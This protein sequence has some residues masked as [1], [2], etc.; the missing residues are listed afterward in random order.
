MLAKHLLYRKYFFDHNNS[1]GGTEIILDDDIYLV[2]RE[3]DILA[4][5]D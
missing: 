5:L 2:L 4:V 3:S 1:N